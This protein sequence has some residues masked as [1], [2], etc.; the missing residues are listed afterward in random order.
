MFHVSF[1]GKTSNIVLRVRN[2]NLLSLSPIL[3]GPSF[4]LPLIR[5]IYHGDG[6]LQSLTAII[7]LG[8]TESFFLS[9]PTEVNRINAEPILMTNFVLTF[10]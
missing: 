10:V 7:R 5:G 8:I 3:R 2:R 6:T 9:C 1:L 4:E